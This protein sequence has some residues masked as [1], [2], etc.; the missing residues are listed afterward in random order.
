[1]VEV[2]G[3][4]LRAGDRVVRRGH[5]GLAD[6]MTVVVVDGQQAAVATAGPALDVERDS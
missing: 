1:M 2:R 4:G 3:G 5:G 6:G